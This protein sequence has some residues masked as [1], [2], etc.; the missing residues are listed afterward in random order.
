MRPQ[1]KEGR[2]STAP[3]CE[4]LP[5][6]RGPKSLHGGPSDHFRQSGLWF[7]QT[8]PTPPPNSGKADTLDEAKAD[9]KARYAEVKGK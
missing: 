5:A 7:L 9:F 3:G 8:E 1:Q 4:H 2:R 6:A